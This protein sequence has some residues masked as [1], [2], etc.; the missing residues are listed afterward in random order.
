MDKNLLITIVIFLGLSIFMLFLFIYILRRDKIIEQRLSAFELSLEELN[1]EIHQL[2]RMRVENSNSD[3]KLE[4]IER[5]IESIVDDIRA[6]EQRNLKII[7]ELKEEVESL[8]SK[9]RKQKLPEI[10]NIISKSDEERVI[11]LYKNGYS[12]EDISRE[13]RIP[14]GEI[15]LILKFASI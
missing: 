12:I 13:L 11:T 15:E 7:E 8:K 4:K 9:I 2:K 14:A 5:I 6:I 1:R 10:N 3:E